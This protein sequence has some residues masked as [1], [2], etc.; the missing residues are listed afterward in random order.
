M[1]YF[2][3]DSHAFHFFS[4]YEE[5]PEDNRGGIHVRKTDLRCL[6]HAEGQQYTLQMF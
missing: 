6:C 4:Q 3:T 2:N 1:P 5:K